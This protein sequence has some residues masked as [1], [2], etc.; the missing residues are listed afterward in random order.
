[1]LDRDAARVSHAADLDGSDGVHFEAIDVLTNPPMV[2]EGDLLVGLHAC[3]ELSDAVVELAARSGAAVMLVSCC[4]QKMRAAERKP[5]S[6][7]AA[8]GVF[9]VSRASLGLST[10]AARDEGVEVPLET[11]LRARQ[12]RCALLLLLRRRGL[13]LQWGDEMRGIN[14]RRAR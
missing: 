14:R 1:G 13:V 4:L 10:L 7:G 9:A 8:G 12:S 6:R 11:T 3:G 5:L 2:G